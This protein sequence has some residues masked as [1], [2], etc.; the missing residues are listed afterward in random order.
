MRS[1]HIEHSPE[2]IK[3]LERV[4]RSRI[5]ANIYKSSDGELLLDGDVLSWNVQYMTS[6]TKF[7]ESLLGFCDNEVIYTSKRGDMF[8]LGEID[9]NKYL[10]A[11]LNTDGKHYMARI[12]TIFSSDAILRAH[13]EDLE[14]W[15][16][17]G[18]LPKNFEYKNITQ[19]NSGDNTDTANKQV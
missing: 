1:Y 15:E 11:R 8:Y 9:K 19:Y 14:S 4:S 10:I 6:N 17:L 13:I 16:R 7:I 2:L 3:Q 12:V 5:L 18:C